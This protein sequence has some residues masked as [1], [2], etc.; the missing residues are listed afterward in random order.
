LLSTI[1][2]AGWADA[3]AEAIRQTTPNLVLHSRQPIQGWEIV[4]QDAARRVKI[5]LSDF[6]YET[7][8]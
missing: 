6:L 8:L 5:E 2:Q 7:L 4:P 1:D 3:I